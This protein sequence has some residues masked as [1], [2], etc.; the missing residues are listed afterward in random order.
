[1]TIRDQRE[2]LGLLFCVG[3]VLLLYSETRK[4]TPP[5]PKLPLPTTHRGL[6]FFVVYCCVS[7]KDWV[8]PLLLHSLYC[9][10]SDGGWSVHMTVHVIMRNYWG[11]IRLAPQCIAEWKFLEIK[12]K[13]RI[14]LLTFL[15]L[16]SGVAAAWWQER[17]FV[18]FIDYKPQ[19]RKI[20]G[21]TIMGKGV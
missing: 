21:R 10:V 20:K 5:T 15:G 16:C 2:S 17:S 11:D 8:L 13:E 18:W 3:L 4:E 9:S 12:R 6:G 14:Y 1:M 7:T 19:N